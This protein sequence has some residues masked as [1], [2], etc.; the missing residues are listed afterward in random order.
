LDLDRL[1]ERIEEEISKYGT[2]KDFRIVV[3][4]QEPDEKGCNWNGRIERV[5]GSTSQDVSWWDV[6]PQ[7]RERYNLK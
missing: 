2:L 1:D 6:L 5:R 7:L 3:W 4:L